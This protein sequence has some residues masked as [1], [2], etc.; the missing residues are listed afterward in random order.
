MICEKCG[1]SFS[2]DKMVALMVYPNPNRRMFCQQCA[3]SQIPAGHKLLMISP[4]R[5]RWWQFWK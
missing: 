5:K 4:K 1:R 3:K 2:N